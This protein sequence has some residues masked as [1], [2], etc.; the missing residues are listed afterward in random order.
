[1]D[2]DGGGTE[3]GPGVDK[4]LVV[5]LLLVGGLLALS[6]FVER[7]PGMDTNDFLLL[8][9]MPGQEFSRAFQIKSTLGAISGMVIWVVLIFRMTCWNGS[10]INFGL[11]KMPMRDATLWSAVV[12][13]ILVLVQLAFSFAT[14]GLHPFS[15]HI[16]RTSIEWSFFPYSI[17]MTL[18]SGLVP[19]R[20]VAYTQGLMG[21][22]FKHS[23][24]VPWVI[25]LVHG[26]T[27][28]ATGKPASVVRSLVIGAVM[29]VSR[30]K[31]GYAWPAIFG[32]MLPNLIL[33]VVSF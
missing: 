11:G 32:F 20:L 25:A 22:L 4:R 9:K 7:L 8:A 30:Y 2:V 29:A 1:M 26:A 24:I 23:D 14:R 16:P 15:S 28:M 19:L 18:L 3:S 17:L 12:G 31:S 10:K 5:E 21:Q 6:H 13:S 27:A 33:E